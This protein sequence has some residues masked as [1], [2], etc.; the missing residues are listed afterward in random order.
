MRKYVLYD[1]IID[2]NKTSALATSTKELLKFLNLEIPVLKKA[3]KDVGC[4]SISLNPKSYYI[5]NAKVLALAAKE[6]SEIICVE[7]SSFLSLRKSKEELAKDDKLR[8]KV[9]LELAKEGLELDLKVKVHTLAQFLLNVVGITKIKK[10][11]KNSF[12]KFNASLYLGSYKCQIDKYS[13]TNYYTIL[14]K[15]T[16]ITLLNYNLKNQVSGYEIYDVNQKLS[17]RMA[18]EL[19]LD[20]FDNA[21]DFVVVN[22]ARSFIM[23]DNY[24]KELE[25]S[26]NREI[27]LSVFGLAEILLLAFGV[28]D[29]GKIGLKEHKIKTSIV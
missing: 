6:Q 13:D 29:K 28:T 27:E 15:A 14:L 17:F 11:I 20:M 19:M 2:I 24:Q 25:K 8:E 12:E 21:A 10:N 5:A 9:E 23:F 16:G 3:P 26:V 22:D 1:A 4:E 18:G 7:D